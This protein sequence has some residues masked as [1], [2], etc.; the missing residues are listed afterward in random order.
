[1]LQK[2]FMALSGF[3]LS[4]LFA[5][6]FDASS[7]VSIGNFCALVACIA[8]V[9]G[10]V[11][12]VGMSVPHTVTTHE[13]L[14]DS[15][16]SQRLLVARGTVPINSRSGDRVVEVIG[17]SAP[18]AA[19][20]P[21]VIANS[22]DDYV[23]QPGNRASRMALRVGLWMLTIG[24]AFFCVISIALAATPESFWKETA[25][26]RILSTVAW[27]SVA[28]PFGFLV[29]PFVAWK[30]PWGPG[31]LAPGHDAAATASHQGDDGLTPSSHSPPP[32][33]ACSWSPLTTPFMAN[34]RT[35]VLWNMWLV[36]FAVWGAGAVVAGNQSQMFI[37]ANDGVFDG[38]QVAMNYAVAGLGGALGR[39]L[40]GYISSHIEHRTLPS[41]IDRL[42]GA[43][44]ETMSSLTQPRWYPATVAYP[45]PPLLCAIGLLLFVVVPPTWFP[46]A[47]LFF[48]VGF[49]AS[50]ATS[51]LCVRVVFR[52]DL[53]RHYAFIFSS[54][55][56]S[57]PLLNSG[58]FASIYDH[59]THAVTATAARR[60]LALSAVS[61]SAPTT[62]AASHEV[63]CSSRVCY[64][65][66]TWVLCAMNAIAIVSAVFVHRKLSARVVEGPPGA[67]QDIVEESSAVI[68]AAKEGPT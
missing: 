58:L 32:P 21:I 52:R 6:Y 30:S 14:L 54:G 39:V 67:S 64:S 35:S 40:A 57:I 55:V 65:A 10:G 18:D 42:L 44:V 33:P 37:A 25:G 53:G 31:R 48:G 45:L 7:A 36:S 29:L 68:G 43:R 56:A 62:T 61:G 34:L 16:L 28:F 1:M 3:I 47:N 66:A 46:L 19:T 22:Y 5:A 60:L 17:G 50:W 59:E 27:L 38:R 12:I 20:T 4:N 9:C 13:D 24:L 2:T 11:A 23:L 51:A 8:F 26:H 49:G 41:W 63:Q 15:T